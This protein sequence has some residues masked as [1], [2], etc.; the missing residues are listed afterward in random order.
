MQPEQRFLDLLDGFLRDGPD[1]FEIAPETCWRPGPDGEFLP[2]GFSDAFHALGEN[3]GKPFVA[4]G[5]GFSVGSAKPDP[6][7]RASWMQAIRRDHERFNFRWYTDHLG[8]CAPAGHQVLLPLCLPYTADASQAVA[9]SLAEL[10]SIVPD[11][12]VENSVFYFHLGNP[13]DEPAW[14]NACLATPRTHLLLDLHNVYTTALNAG[15]DARRY[16]D[17]LDLSRVIEIHVSGGAWSEPGWLPSGKVLRLDSHDKEVPE[18]VWS[19]LD[20]VLPRCP[21]LRGVTLERMEGSVE[22]NDVPIL[23]GELQRIRRCLESAHVE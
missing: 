6:V 19:L 4:H 1:Y 2:N 18:E 12:G 9:R 11:V 13:F 14:L 21:N 7:R 20:S 15:F 10:Q 23:T 17:A 22:P 8:T 3:T 5:V 16:I